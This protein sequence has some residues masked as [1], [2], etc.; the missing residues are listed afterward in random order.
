MIVDKHRKEEFGVIA[1]TDPHTGAQ[2][3]NLDGCGRVSVT[4]V[5]ESGSSPVGTFKLQATN[6]PDPTS[7]NHWSDLS[8]SLNI[9]GDDGA[10]SL[11]DGAAGYRHVRA[12]FQLSSGSAT[13]TAYITAKGA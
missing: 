8:P 9:S 4:L 10:L 2:P 5:W 1:D 11:S 13:F 7:D 6:H 12:H 3:T